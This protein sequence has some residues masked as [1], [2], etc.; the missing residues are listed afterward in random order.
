[1]LGGGG[2][3]NVGLRASIYSFIIPFIRELKVLFSACQIWSKNAQISTLNFD[4]FLSCIFPV[5]IKIT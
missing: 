3:H 1:V 2:G 4:R 5:D